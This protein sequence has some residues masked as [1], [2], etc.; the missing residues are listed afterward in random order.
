MLW[1][2]F[3]VYLTAAA[4]WLIYCALATLSPHKQGLSAV[5]AM[6]TGCSP[7]VDYGY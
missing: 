6:G 3:I 2:R 5:R 7:Y 4:D 1:S